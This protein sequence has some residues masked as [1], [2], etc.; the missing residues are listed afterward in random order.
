LGELREWSEGVWI[1]AAPLRFYGIP[2]GTRMTAIRLGD[3]SLWLHSPIPLPPTLRAALQAHGPV[4]HLVSPNKL[5]H[6]FF[7]PARAAFPEARLYAPPGL[8]RKRPDLAF[9]AELGDAAPA[10]WEGQLDQA[11]VRG[12][13][14]M[15]EVVFFHPPSR[16]LLVGDLCEHFGPWSPW[17]TRL[18][19]RLARMYGRPRM[20]PDWQ[21]SFRDREATRASFERILAWDFDRVILAHG[22]LLES[23][24]KERFERAYAWASGTR[25]PR[26]C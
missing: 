10:A 13:T 16:T 25:S 14:L 2:F 20:P 23:S 3:G 5:H 15:E 1:A 18:V 12:S 4:R 24:A 22:A 21:L 26:S 11:V 8:A 9:D 17:P 6:L 7:G 19:A